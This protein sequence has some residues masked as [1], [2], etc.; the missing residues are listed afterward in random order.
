LHNRVLESTAGDVV[1]GLERF[2]DDRPQL[3]FA[4]Q[5]EGLA[6]VSTTAGGPSRLRDAPLSRPLI[7]L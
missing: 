5:V 4:Q 7:F 6:E 3:I 2:D 1:E